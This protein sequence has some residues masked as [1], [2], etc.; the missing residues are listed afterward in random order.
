MTNETRQKVLIS[1]HSSPGTPMRRIA[2]FLLV[3]ICALLLFYSLHNHVSR[4]KTVAPNTTDP[5]NVYIITASG[6]RAEHL[7]SYL[8]QPIQTPAIDFLAY[9]GVRFTNAYTTSTES[10][11]AHL[12]LLT[13]LYPVQKQILECTNS[14]YAN[15]DY[16][17][18]TTLPDLLTGAGYKTAIFAADPEL[19]FPEFF[20]DHFQHVSTGAE[21]LPPWKS[22]YSS[23]EVLGLAHEWILHNRTNP[24]FL[25]LNFDQPAFPF[26][27]PAPY[28]EQYANHPYDGEIAALDEQIGLFV[29][30]LRKEQLFQ[31]SV[32]V[33]TSPYG[34]TLPGQSRY[35]SPHRSNLHVPLMIVA[36]GLL[37]R[38]EL[39]DS[40][41]GLMDVMPT[42]LELL[43]FSER[44]QMDGLSLFQKGERTEISRDSIPGIVPYSKLV[45][46]PSEYFIQSNHFLYVTGSEEVTPHRSFRF[47]D[48]EKTKWMENAR[49]LLRKY[50][51]QSQK[52]PSFEV[53]PAL[54]LESAIHLV[55]QNRPDE[56]LQ[57]L[58]R[59]PDHTKY[60]AELKEKIFKFRI[61]NSK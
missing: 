4:S 50:G 48:E 19:R 27:P 41:V 31:K 58:D 40:L 51:I 37:P 28:R 59:I 35:T 7:S 1:H 23:T 14:L 53:H 36:P 11:T 47:S 38:N 34:E 26:Q 21:L 6:L 56:A 3:L 39:Y 13:G 17:E 54:L 16:P 22:A 57:Q 46:L 33:F 2:L 20:H 49:T 25:L 42:I 61:R 44:P 9:D 55:R 8:Y 30:F 43:E 52:I 18:L 24:H 15:E 32:I 60:I 5:K 29:N 45:G 10:L 12:S